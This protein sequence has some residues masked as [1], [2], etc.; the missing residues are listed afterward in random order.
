MMLTA[1]DAGWEPTT[2]MLFYSTSMIPGFDLATYHIYCTSYTDPVYVRSTSQRQVKIYGKYIVTC[3]TCRV[4]MM[5]CYLCV[6]TP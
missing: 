5:P 3:L 1:H 2:C 6:E 4:A